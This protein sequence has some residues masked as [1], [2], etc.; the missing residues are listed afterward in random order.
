M[1][2]PG[3]DSRERDEDGRIRQKN[4]AVLIGT[5]RETYGQDFAAGHRSDKKLD[6]LLQE[7]NA[8]S[9]SEYLRRGK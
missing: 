7:E 2:E 3:L 5:L 6:T 9:L 8:A 1:K 4:G